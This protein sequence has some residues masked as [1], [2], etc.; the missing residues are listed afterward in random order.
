MQFVLLIDIIDKYIYLYII[1]Y[2]LR[3]IKLKNYLKLRNVGK[4]K[5]I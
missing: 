1:I 4:N 5:S 3:Q 2:E